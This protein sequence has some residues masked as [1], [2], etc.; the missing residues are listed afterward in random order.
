M[1]KFNPEMDLLIPQLDLVRVE[2]EENHSLNKLQEQ[3]RAG[4]PIE[5]GDYFIRIANQV[6]LKS[7]D[8]ATKVGVVLVGSE[9][10]IVSTG[11]N[12][13]PRG[14]Q[15]DLPE[16]QGRPEKYFWFAHGEVNSIVNAARIGVSTMNTDMYMTCG[17]PCC[18]CA[19]SIINAGVRMIICSSVESAHG[20][21]YPEEIKRSVQM[22]E[23]AKVEIVRYD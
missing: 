3:R 14:I 13:F 7:K 21:H 17:I 19:Q 5:W 11:Y 8:R 6:K 20:Q 12:S 4:R 22:F 15:D 18:G 23:E 10:E 9:K 1:K 2:T 16:R